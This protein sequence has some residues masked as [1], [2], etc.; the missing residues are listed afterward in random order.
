MVLH[1]A[2][3]RAKGNLSAAARLLGLTRP[4]L[5]YRLKKESTAADDV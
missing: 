2:V 3:E 4:Q 5:S 1:R